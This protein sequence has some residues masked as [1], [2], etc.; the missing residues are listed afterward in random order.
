M[1]SLAPPDDIE[2]YHVERLEQ[3]NKTA[4]YPQLISDVF[5]VNYDEQGRPTTESS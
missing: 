4:P 1:D 5:V 2:R 3:W